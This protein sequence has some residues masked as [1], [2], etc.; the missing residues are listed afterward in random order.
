MSST[1]H[2]QEQ[3]HAQVLSA[4][5][6]DTKPPKPT[7]PSIPLTNPT[8]FAAMIALSKLSATK[9]V[10]ASPVIAGGA[11]LLGGQARFQMVAYG[12][13]VVAQAAWAAAQTVGS[14]WV[15]HSMTTNFTAPGVVGL[16]F[17]YHVRTATDGSSYS[18]RIVEATQPQTMA[19]LGVTAATVTCRASVSFKRRRN[20]N[21]SPFDCQAPP[22][23]AVQQT[24]ARLH[25]GASPHP[26]ALVPVSFDSL[27][28]LLAT[29]YAADEPL[30]TPSIAG[31]EAVLLP[32]RGHGERGELP[33]PLCAHF[34]F[35]QRS[36]R[37]V[38]ATVYTAAGDASEIVGANLGVCAHLNAVDGITL[39]D[40]AALLG[41]PL[42]RVRAMCTLGMSVVVHNAWGLR[43]ADG[44][45][46]RWFVQEG[47]VERYAD[48]RV[49]FCTRVWNDK[50]VCV[51][52]SWQE[53]VLKVAEGVLKVAKGARL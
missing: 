5:P 25:A 12:G 34:P 14:E 28:A 51:L 46:K 23:P 44:E 45:S 43:I 19:D 27:Q 8:S 35:A 33:S 36:P 7:Y 53:G 24:L 4:T 38:T 52:S 40:A 41:V 49:V 39:W 9:F 6:L 16:P 26:A 18:L 29:R 11:R 22:S 1:M 30:Y 15:M 2:E 21:T 3:E 17:T 37:R 31:V 10:N 48:E 47:W 32:L 20:N 50:G 42:S 13:Q